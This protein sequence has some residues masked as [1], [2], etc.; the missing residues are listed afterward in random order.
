M[1]STK[2]V[3]AVK[4]SDGKIGVPLDENLSAMDRVNAIFGTSLEDVEP[5]EV[6]RT[7]LSLLKS[8]SEFLYDM[9]VQIIYKFYQ[10]SYL[11]NL[12]LRRSSTILA[13]PIFPPLPPSPSTSISHTTQKL[14]HPHRAGEPEPSQTN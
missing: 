13:L 4:R 10:R 11:S 7:S 6:S 2:N 12:P 3:T 1:A 8:L 9:R 5:Y 14:T